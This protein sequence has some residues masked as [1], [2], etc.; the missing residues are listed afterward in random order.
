MKGPEQT[1]SELDELATFLMLYQERVG[2]AI[3]NSDT[4]THTFSREEVDSLATHTRTDTGE[5]ESADSDIHAV[6]A[7][8]PSMSAM[9]TFTDARAN[10]DRDDSGVQTQTF[11]KDGR[12]QTDTDISSGAFTAFP[13]S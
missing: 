13:R 7:A 4:R 1:K 9:Q 3:S 2:A 10:A 6:H 5:R 11:S 12:E 8:F